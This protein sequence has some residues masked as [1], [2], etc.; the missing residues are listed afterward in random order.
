MTEVEIFTK[1]GCGWAERNYAALIEKGVAFRTV[2]SADP[3][4][5]KTTEFLSLSPYGRTPVLRFGHEVVWESAVMNEFIDD[6][7]PSPPLRPSDPAGRARS[8]LWTLHCDSVLMPA[9]N[10][11]ARAGGKAEAGAGDPTA[12]NLALLASWWGKRP[13]GGSL[14]RGERLSLVDIVF[15]TYFQALDVVEAMQGGAGKVLPPELLAWKASIAAHS[16][17]Q[18]AGEIARK[19]DL[20]GAGLAEM[21]V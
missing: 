11:L 8:R 2:M 18:A 13:S 16:S 15:H 7:F 21:E 19:L 1:P 3:N 9:L 12:S 4:G 20:G 5:R 6:R 14:W 10:A 17:I